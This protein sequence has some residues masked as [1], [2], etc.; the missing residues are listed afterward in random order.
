MTTG[1]R[2]RGEKGISRKATAQGR[3]GV[4]GFTCM[5]LCI[6]LRY[7]R[8]ADRG[9]QPAPGLP[10]ALLIEEGGEMKQSSGKTCRENA[11]V[12]LVFD[13]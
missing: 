10:C 4:S 12:R 3:P 11:K 8:T 9:C 13:A 5:P 2:R 1:I 6:C 7:L